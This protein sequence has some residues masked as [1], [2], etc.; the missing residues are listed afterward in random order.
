MVPRPGIEPGTQGFSIL[1]STKLQFTLQLL[2][3]NCVYYC[4]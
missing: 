3:E 2:T 4:V 1:L